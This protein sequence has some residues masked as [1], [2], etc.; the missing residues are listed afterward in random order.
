MSASSSGFL[1][2][3]LRAIH[4]I[5]EATMI[6][7]VTVLGD[8]QVDAAGS[9]NQYLVCVYW[10]DRGS[11]VYIVGALTISNSRLPIIEKMRAR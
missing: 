2:R 5:D 3:R 11:I 10:S 4:G 8:E 7:G 9:N 1:L 6:H